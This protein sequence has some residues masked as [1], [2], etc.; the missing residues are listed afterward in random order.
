M[1]EKA[2]QNDVM[3]M[4]RR[5]IT[6]YEKPENLLNYQRF[7][8]E[9]LD[10]P[11]GLKTAILRKIS[12][13]VF[14]SVKHLPA[15]EIFAL[16]D[17]LLTSRERYTRFL[18]FDWALRID[19]HY[20]PQDMKRFERWLKRN[21]DGWASCDHLCTGPIGRLILQFPDLTAKTKT[22]APSKN[23]WLR[24]ASAVS[25]IISARKGFLLDDVF[26]TA[27]LLLLDPDDM[28]QKGYGWMLKE[29]SRQHPQEVFHYV[30]KHRDKM[31]RT[32]LRY[33]IEKLPPPRR[34]Q[35]M[36]K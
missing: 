10:D 11:I 8:K 23:R 17:R 1:T 30:M 34:R 33:A 3:D 27:D 31:P 29:A 26:A 2:K 5:E 36:S 21:V 16:C 35:A 19:R 6:R 25:L 14:T 9:Q 7:F 4:L 32:A 15:P 18:A 24:R 12:G 13:S 28:V 20:C 22:W